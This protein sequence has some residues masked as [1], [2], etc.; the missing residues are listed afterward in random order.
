MRFAPERAAAF[1]VAVFRASGIK[2]ADATRV[3][4]VLLAADLRGIRS[5]GVGRLPF[6]AIR[7]ERGVINP[8]PAMSLE[9]R[10]HTTASL[11]ADNGL[12]ILAADRAMH[13]AMGMAASHGSG[14]VSVT[15]SNHFGF[16]GYWADLARRHGFIGISMSN[17]ARR[18]TPTFG[19]ESLLGTNPL[20]VAIPGGAGGTDFLLDMGTSVVAAGKLETA[21]REDRVIPDGWVSEYGSSPALDQRGVLTYDSLL[22]PLGGEGDETGGH[23]GYGL[24]L[25]VELLCGALAGSPL[26]TRVATADG[27]GPAAMGHFFGALQ[28]EGFRSP[29]LVEADMAATF[30]TLRGAKKA[31]GH[32]RVY[33]HGEPE[34]IAEEE[35]RRLGIP[36][37]PRLLEQMRALNERLDLGFDV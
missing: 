15:A 4:E 13:E 37:T 12:G 32:D 34:S 19:A 18:V 6:F 2:E 27:S 24:S 30:D 31:P 22:L 20:A 23:K 35:N 36:I 29:E 5:H 33:I 21:L 8:A 7:L 25:L 11:D 1:S 26:G 9:T 16:A 28:V 14:F 10:T 17:S 3:A